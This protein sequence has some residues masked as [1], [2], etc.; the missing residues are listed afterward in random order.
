MHGE[1]LTHHAMTST[2]HDIDLLLELAFLSLADASGLF[3]RHS[4]IRGSSPGW[5]RVATATH[6]ASSAIR[7]ARW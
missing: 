2:C 5:V 6:V 3:K 4:P 7:H 1:L